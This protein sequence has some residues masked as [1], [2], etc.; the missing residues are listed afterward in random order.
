MLKQRVVTAVLLGL[1]VLLPLFFLPD[2]A[3]GGLIA[4][5]VAVALHEWCAL[6]KIERLGQVLLSALCILPILYCALVPAAT[7][8][9]LHFLFAGAYL[10]SISFWLF[11][12]PSFL[13]FH[14][15]PAGWYWRYGVGVVMTIP[16]AIAMLELRRESPLLMLAAVLFVCVADI[17]A[18]FAGRTFGKRKLAPQISPGKTWEG[19]VG[20]VGATLLFCCALWF[21]VPQ[22]RQAFS[23]VWVIALTLVFVAVCVMGDLFESLVKREAGV[24]DS[25]S[26]LPGHGGVLDR[27]DAMLAFFPFAGCVLLF[28]QLNA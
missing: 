22:V 14:M 28:L 21:F 27:I 18:F 1:G 3:W 9:D 19:V 20:A 11:S 2:W 17:A 4:G 16:T 12:V 5:V 23:L 25:G 15:E 26:L 10:V 24:K 6:V 7:S 8:N 13:Y